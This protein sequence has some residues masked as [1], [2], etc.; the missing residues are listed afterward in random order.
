MALLD[1]I[2][3][4]RPRFSNKDLSRTRAMS[5][6]PGPLY[7]A[8]CERAFNGDTW[9]IRTSN[10][11]KTYPLKS[12]FFGT[13]R[14]QLCWFFVPDRLYTP[15]LDVNNPEFDPDTVE[16]PTEDIK[17]AFAFQ[18]GDETATQVRIPTF[19]AASYSE[20][21]IN[22]R[23]MVGQVKPSSLLNQL[24]FPAG[25]MRVHSPF[26]YNATPLYGYF[27]IFL[28][29]FCNTQEAGYYQGVMNNSWAIDNPLNVFGGSI[30]SNGIKWI[31]QGGISTIGDWT[32]FY[33]GLGTDPTP[34]LNYKRVKWGY[35]PLTQSAAA[36][37]KTS[38]SFV[39]Q[40][41]KERSNSWDVLWSTVD[42]IEYDK[43]FLQTATAPDVASMC[44]PMGGLVLRSHRPDLLN[45]W[46][47]GA[48]YNEMVKR[49]RIITSG[50]ELPSLSQ[51]FTINQL[52]LGSHLLKYYERG[53]VAGGRYDDW[54]EAQF[55]IKTDNQL[56]IP[57][58]LGVHS[59]TI[60]FNDV[61]NTA[62]PSSVDDNGSNFS[63]NTLG[64]L[65]GR[66]FGS[67]KGKVRFT[68]KEYG[69]V[70]G[71][72]SIVP[73]CTYSQG[74]KDWMFDHDFGD[75]YT[76]AMQTIGFQ[77]LL[78]AYAYALPNYQ[79][80]NSPVPGVPNPS[81]YSLYLAEN[82]G[83]I[84]SP[85]P[86]SSNAGYLKPSY[87]PN[88][89][90]TTDPSSFYD[91]AT[92]RYGD[93]LAYG[94]QPAW[95]P[96]STAINES[97]G[98][99]DATMG[100]LSYWVPVRDYRKGNG[101]SIGNPTGSGGLLGRFSEGTFTS[102]VRPDQFNF[103]FDNQADDAENFLVHFGFDVFCRRAMSKSVMP[104]LC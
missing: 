2:Y 6:A 50:T 9:V 37:G 85:G 91:D 34:T 103:P 36:K 17:S 12:P 104:T 25:F 42:Q 19:S 30:T 58:L 1:S 40:S 20:E 87:D 95:T 100:D 10:D 64:S 7:V 46:V 27:D 44:V 73:N 57:E 83:L 86:D 65:A 75:L 24:G 22:P 80:S 21:V 90:M 29:Y 43:N 51:S 31:T 68:C 55:G 72:Y 54:L 15:E 33:P 61:V 28:N 38:L 41:L 4:E 92:S 101:V 59:S 45:A 48:N 52:R 53:L 39:I 76:P 11:V 18:T 89:N 56:L 63:G 94:Y 66:G 35:F 81:G 77:P 3:L 70:M 78:T 67:L 99:F 71:I 96:Y 82:P 16:L 97:I 32:P 49:T 84:L 98:A 102:Y 26:R 13:F 88:V 62:A 8:F 47:S 93:Y 74:I 14:Q 23:F 5:C 60:A 69:F 79:V